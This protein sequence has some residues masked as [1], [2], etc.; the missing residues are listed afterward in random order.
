MSTI[1]FEISYARLRLSNRESHYNCSD[2]HYLVNYHQE[3]LERLRLDLLIFR[4]RVGYM[5]T[6]SIFNLES[7][8]IKHNEE[9]PKIKTNT[10][11]DILISKI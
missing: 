3:R 2:K 4:N 1:Y 8:N 11:S 6:F 9:T 5:T 7:L 10:N